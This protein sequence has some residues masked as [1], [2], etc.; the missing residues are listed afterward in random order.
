MKVRDG[1]NVE[2]GFRRTAEVEGASE[3]E[4]SEDGADRDE[5]HLLRDSSNAV[6]RRD[7]LD[8]DEATVVHKRGERTVSV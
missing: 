2:S 7:T 3:D 8:G 4:H 6:G 5:S 1:A